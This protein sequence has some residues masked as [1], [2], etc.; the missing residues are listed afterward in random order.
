ME[1]RQYIYIKKKKR[2]KSCDIKKI[3]NDEFYKKGRG[4]KLF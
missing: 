1:T 3:N 2:K 4:T